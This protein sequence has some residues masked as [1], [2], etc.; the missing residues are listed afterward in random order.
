[1]EEF[2]DFGAVQKHRAR[3]APRLGAVKPV[4]DELAARLLD[5]LDDTTRIFNLAL[6]FGGRGAVAPALIA[7]SMEV[8]SVDFSPAMADQAGGTP[9]VIGNPDDFGLDQARYDLV[10]AHL[11]LHWLNDLPG[12]LIQLRRALKPDGLLLASLPVLGTLGALRE[13]LLEAELALTGGVSPRVSPFPAL[14]DCA[15]LLQRAGFA[16]PVADAEE[17]VFEYENPMRLLLDLR[18]AGETNAVQARSRSF[19]PR[20]LLPMALNTLPE[21]DGRKIVTLRMAVLTGWA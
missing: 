20:T 8:D 9:W 4:L 2:F 1:M 21:R 11:V 6:D 16:L 18:D 10:V 13:A 19:M 3:A 17:I 14:G 12:A 5:R 7:R 15:G